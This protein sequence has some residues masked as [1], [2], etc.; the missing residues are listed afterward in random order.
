MTESKSISDIVVSSESI[1]VRS[2]DSGQSVSCLLSGTVDVAVAEGVVL[3]LVLGVELAGGD[4]GNSSTDSSNNWSSLGDDGSSS[5]KW[6]CL[7]DDRSGSN[8]TDSRS[9]NNWGSSDCTDNSWSSSNSADSWNS[10]S[11]NYSTKCWGCVAT[12]IS[13]WIAKR[14]PTIGTICTIESIGISLSIGA[15]YQ[16]R[17]KNQNLHVVMLTVLLNDVPCTLR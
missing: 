1:R 15:G 4:S 6:S 5:N 12:S 3:V 17:D 2:G 14:S 10:R 16:S 13:I 7:G 9:S 8:S 11:S